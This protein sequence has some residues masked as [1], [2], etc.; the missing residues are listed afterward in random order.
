MPTLADIL[1]DETDRPKSFMVGDGEF[2]PVKVGFVPPKGAKNYQFDT[3]VKGNS[4]AGHNYGTDLD[5]QSKKALIE[6]LK[7]L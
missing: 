2:D 5:P 4:N 3:S 6:Y 1:E 7:S